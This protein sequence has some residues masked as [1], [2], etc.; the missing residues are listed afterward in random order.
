MIGSIMSLSISLPLN[1]LVIVLLCS[2]LQLLSAFVGIVPPIATGRLANR[3]IHCLTYRLVSGIP[4]ALFS[5][6]DGAGRSW[7]GPG[8]SARR[9][10]S[11]GNSRDS[12]GSREVE[13]ARESLSNGRREGRRSSDN[14]SEKELSNWKSGKVFG[15][16]GERRRRNNDPWWMREEEKNNPRIISQYKPWWMDRNPLVDRTWKVAELREEATRRNL[17][18]SGSKSELIDKLVASSRM[19]D[20]SDSNFR[21]PTFVSSEEKAPSKCYPEHYEGTTENIEKLRLTIGARQAP[22]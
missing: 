12:N 1:F 6:E 20:L 8:D 5:T 4:T 13:G 16:N 17:D 9:T 7:S 2:N 22:Q 15:Q 19:Y 10:R 3:R 18:T 11:S 14:R 21:V